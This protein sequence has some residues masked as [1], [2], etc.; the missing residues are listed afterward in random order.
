MRAR[1]APAPQDMPFAPF[2]KTDKL[3]KA[4]DWTNTGYQKYSGACRGRAHAA[5]HRR[6]LVCRRRARAGGGGRVGCPDRGRRWHGEWAR[7][8]CPC[9]G[10]LTCV[11]RADLHP[12]RRAGRQAPVT[13]VFTFFQNEEVRGGGWRASRAA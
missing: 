6:A 13:T 12:L 5:C 9:C 11:P 7:G 10:S 3:G 2:S 8:S 4:A 1:T